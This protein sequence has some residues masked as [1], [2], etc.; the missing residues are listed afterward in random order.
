M[1]VYARGL[2]LV[3]LHLRGSRLVYRG[4]LRRRKHGKICQPRISQWAAMPHVRRWRCRHRILLIASGGQCLADL[5]RRRRIDE[6]T[7]MD[8]RLCAGKALSPTLVGLLRTPFNIGGYI[9]LKFSLAWGLACLLI[10]KVIHPGIAA[11][12]HHIPFMLSCILL[13]IFGAL[14]ICDLVFTVISV[15][16]LNVHLEQ[17][18]KV[19]S[20]IRAASDDIGGKMSEQTIKLMHRQSELMEHLRGGEKRLMA[21]FP[22]MRSTRYADLMEK[23]RE[24]HFHLSEKKQQSEKSHS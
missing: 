21:A 23:L 7:G 14:L 5:P 18:S 9:C 3:F 17:L 22:Q 10:L 2:H 6:R 19:T 20:M 13:P 1:C 15:R 16:S 4:H 11:L 12:V 8:H 24:K